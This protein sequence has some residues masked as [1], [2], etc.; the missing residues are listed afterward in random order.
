MLKFIERLWPSYP[1]ELEV[2]DARQKLQFYIERAEKEEE[3]L[4]IDEN[5]RAALTEGRSSAV[6]LLAEPCA[7]RQRSDYIRRLEESSGIL[8]ELVNVAEAARSK[9]RECRELIKALET[10]TPSLA[11]QLPQA[12]LKQTRDETFVAAT[13]LAEKRYEEALLQAKR[14][15]NSSHLARKVANWKL[16][17]AQAQ[18]WSGEDTAFDFIQ[19]FPD[20][21]VSKD[22]KSTFSAM[23]TSARDARQI[24]LTLAWYARETK[25]RRYC[26]GVSAWGY[27]PLGVDYGRIIDIL[28][29][30]FCH[31]AEFQNE[32]TW[33]LEAILDLGVAY[34][35]RVMLGIPRFQPTAQE[36]KDEV[37]QLTEDCEKAIYHLGEA[38]VMAR[39]L[40]VSR[41]KKQ[42]IA[43]RIVAC[44]RYRKQESGTE[45]IAD[46]RRILASD[47]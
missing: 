18:S 30:R 9:A 4:Y 13:L 40:G 47:S 24:S 23:R 38:L 39:R 14:A 7:C 32:S 41:E 15:V 3:E 43:A 8:R 22:W 2:G 19:P 11:A 27:V 28:H 20:A 42:I 35:N 5:T 44:P 25:T 37:R 16:C 21:D 10:V 29:T 12:D 26:F 6:L 31:L 45:T 17:L 33:M 1:S 36:R 46:A 34:G